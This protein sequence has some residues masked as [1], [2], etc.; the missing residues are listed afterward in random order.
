MY[1]KAL[2]CC[3]SFWVFSIGFAID[4]QQSYN[5]NKST[6]GTVA[7]V[8]GQIITLADVLRLCGDEEAK[9]PVMYGAEEAREK[10][11]ILR[12]VALEKLIKRKLVFSDFIAH[13]Y[14]F[15]YGF[16]VNYLDKIAS[17]YK[18]PNAEALKNK[19]EEEGGN[20]NEFSKRAYEDAAVNSLVYSHCYKNVF[21]TP[22]E[23]YKYYCQNSKYYTKSPQ[24]D[25][26]VILLKKNGYYRK[27]LKQFSVKLETELK[28]ADEKKF[29]E[30]AL[31]YSE[32]PKKNIGGDIGWVPEDKLRKDFAAYLNNKSVG[33]IVGP[34]ITEEGNYFL[35]LKE[36]K[37]EYREPYRYVREEI[38]EMLTKQR[39]Q[40]EYDAYINSLKEKFKIKYF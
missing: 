38:K 5:G 16:M 19:I 8:N 13:K 12:T 29:S 21:I 22:K 25:I 15:P 1:K 11:H 23:I 30:Y 20:F 37:A 26:Q 18:L 17:F 27:E 2:Y 14:Q 24:V 10:S 7:S 6:D 33:D 9:L 34:I 35:R 39:Q 36:K 40:K 28:N 4:I 3:L 31:M 32:G